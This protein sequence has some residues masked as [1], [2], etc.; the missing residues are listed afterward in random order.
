M[1]SEF[2]LFIYTTLAGIV[3]GGYVARA[4][5]PLPTEQKPPWL[6]SLV[7][8]VLAAVG[9]LVLFAHLGRPERFFN[10]FSNFQAGIAQEGVATVVFY[11][12]IVAD[13][14]WCIVKKGSSRR[15][16]IATAVLGVILAVATGFAYLECLGAPAWTSIATVPFF[17]VGDLGM[18][19]GFYL[20]F[21]RNALAEKNFK[22]Y[23]IV[24]QILTALSIVALAIRFASVGVSILPLVAGI[25]VGPVLFC[26]LDLVGKKSEKEQYEWMPLA[27]CACAIVGVVIARYGFY[28]GYVI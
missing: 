22:M 23:S 10:A 6:F 19:A 9:C 7:S 28:L 25:I 21:N 27:L 17:V 5:K 18:G 20:L 4:I 15:L 24:V 12:A 2:P 14:V 13:L 1:I 26:V 8:L 3:A 16:V 11:S